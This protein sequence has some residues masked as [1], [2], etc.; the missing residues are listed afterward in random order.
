MA[1]RDIQFGTDQHRGYLA[2]SATGS[3]PGVIVI[4]EWWGLVPHIQEVADRFAAEGF[5]ALAPDFY[6]GEK[7]TDPDEAGRLMMALEIEHA[8]RVLEEAIS[9]LL[10]QPETSGEK[11][12]VVGFCMGGQLALYA[13][14]TSDRVAATVCFYGIHPNVHPPFERMTAKVLGIFAEEDHMTT[15]AVVAA[16]DRQLTDLGKEHE[17]VTYPGTDHA[18]FNDHRPEV[19]APEA[20]E[21]AW[22]RTIAFFRQNLGS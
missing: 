3:G 4:Q 8:E 1:G 22:K 20:S 17:F 10:E 5:T 12:G 7:T 9:F 15:P 2:P 11:V 19:H 18:F 21:D 14:A 16:L 6:K 13:G